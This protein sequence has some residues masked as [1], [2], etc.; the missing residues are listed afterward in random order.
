VKVF[1]EHRRIVLPSRADVL[2]VLPGAQKF[3]AGG[4][5]WLAVPHN[6][7]AVRLL[8]NLGLQAPSPIGYYY[9][10]PGGTPFDSQRVTA[11]LCSI[12]RRAYVLSEMGVGKTRAVLWA[13]DYLRREG[14]VRKLLVVAP[15]STL[16]TVWENE[17][18]ENFPHLTA[19]VLHGSKAK[20]LR[21]L[22]EDADVYVINHDGVEV[23]HNELF[24][25]AE[26]D[27]VI[28]D[29]LASYRNKRTARWKYLEP[30]VRRSAYSWG[31]TGS[32]TPNAPTDAYGQSRLLTPEA[33][34]F[35]FK[36]FKDR[37]MRQVSTFTW[38]PRPEANEIAH[39]I[40]QPAV[41]FTR[42]ECLDLP[43]TTYSSRSV[44]LAP[45]AAKAYAEM[46]RQLA[47]QVRSKEITA[48]NEGV[49]LSKLLQIAAGFAYDADGRGHY[50]G[51]VDRFK[52]I[53][54]LIEASSGKVI[55]F[56]PFRYF[57]DLLAGVLGKRFE[58]A[59]IH[60]DVAPQARTR[61]F[62]DFQRGRGDRDIR[63]LIAHPQ[64]MSH[65]LTL[66]AANTII[67]AS[68]TTSLETYQQAN[69]RITRAGQTQNT[70]IIHVA[71]SPAE[72]KVYARLK[73]NAALQGAL[74]ELFEKEAL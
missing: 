41:R 20:R 8:R 52:E 12:A 51:G 48:A 67:W 22:A 10:W 6:V 66:T 29:E 36:A 21:H 4:A 50:V 43:P 13:Y 3:E 44:V 26:I 60:G 7:E 70:H 64:T 61:I 53:I 45:A 9:D 39:S 59:V 11:D 49:K 32:P 47:T 33:A 5:Q 37:T 18:F 55:V 30:I 40:L 16:S 1:P 54:D 68:P 27:G 63:V 74:L 25:R 14:Q 35:S 15:L 69:A 19:K 28:V 38:I 71:G 58:A 2:H 73:R 72:A 46:H 62:A 56:A 42:A 57:V 34:G 17:I 24:A 31:L 65:G 23:I